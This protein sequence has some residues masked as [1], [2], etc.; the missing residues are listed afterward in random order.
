MTFDELKEMIK[1]DIS[2]DETQLDRESVRTPQIH[3]KYLIFFM[4]EKLS[5]TRMSTELDSLKTKKWL[6]Y[7]GRMSADELKE[8]EWEQFDLHVLKQD[9]DR[10]IESDS[11]VIR[12]KIIDSGQFAPLSTGQSSLVVSNKY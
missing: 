1:K 9:L 11:A 10:L 4:E 2:L 8:N 7:S 6:Y 12:Q 3:N 5:L